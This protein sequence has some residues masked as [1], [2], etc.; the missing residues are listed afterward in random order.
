MR[1]LASLSESE[2]QHILPERHSRKTK[3]MTNWS[4]STFEGKL[5]FFR[6]KIV[7]FETQAFNRK[8]CQ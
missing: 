8:N 7:K 2:M 1:L 5:N 3:Q 6:F 4:V